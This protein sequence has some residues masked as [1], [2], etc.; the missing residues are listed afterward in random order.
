MGAAV[1]ASNSQ[2]HAECEPRKL[3]ELQEEMTKDWQPVVCG[4]Q[5]GLVEPGEAIFWGRA[6]EGAQTASHAAFAAYAAE[7]QSAQKGRETASLI[8]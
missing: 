8:G 7:A 3:E 1:D 6:E 4:V 5:A 2:V